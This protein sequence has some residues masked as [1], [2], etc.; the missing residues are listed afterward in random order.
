MGSEPIDLMLFSN[1]LWSSDVWGR[2][3]SVSVV[4]AKEERALNLEPETLLLQGHERP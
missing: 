4:P 2:R 3:H 1:P